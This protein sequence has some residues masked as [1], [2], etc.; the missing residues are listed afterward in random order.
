MLAKNRTKKRL[1]I[2]ATQELSSAYTKNA[3]TSNGKLLVLFLFNYS[4]EMR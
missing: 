1:P 4:K 2:T 3:L